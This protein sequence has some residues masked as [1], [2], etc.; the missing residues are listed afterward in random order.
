MENLIQIKINSSFFT[1]KKGTKVSELIS[2]LNLNGSPLGVKINGQLY[3]LDFTLKESV[4]INLVFP[5]S[6]DGLEI[7]RHSTAHLM[8]QA[9]LQL[10]PGTKTGIGPPIE[11]GYYY[12]FKRDKPFTPEDLEKIEQRM[13]ELAKK[14]IPIKKLILTKEEAIKIFQEKSQE[15]KVE[16]IKEKGEEEVTCYQQGD[17]I[18]FCLGPHLS[19]TSQIRYFKILSSSGAYWKGDEGGIRL[20][21]IYGTAFFRKEDLENYLRAMEEARKRDH[22]KLGPELDLFSINEEIGAGLILWHPKGAIIRKLI[23]DFWKEEHLKNGYDLVYTPHLARLDLWKQSGH[24][25]FYEAMYPPMKI[26]QVEYEIKPMNCPFHIMIY[27]SRQR[28][29]RDLPLRWA[30]L[31]TVYRFERSGVLHGLLRVRGFT[32]DD[33]HIFCS[34]EQLE[35]EIRNVIHLTLKILKTFGFE[36]YEVFLST[37]PEKFVGNLKDWEEATKA[38]ENSLKAMNLEYK[39]DLGEGVFYGPKIDIKIKDAL[40]RAWQCTTIQLDFNLPSRFNLTFTGKDGALHRPIM[41]HRAILGSLERFFGILIEHYKGNFPIWL[42]PVQA[43][44]LPITDKV[45]NYALKIKEILKENGIRCETDLRNEKISYKI[46][47]AEKNKI[48]YMIIIGNKEKKEN[49][50]SLRIHTI[51]DRGKME[52]EKFIEMVLKLDKDKSLKYII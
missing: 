17:F 46:R 18:D 27:K 42:S 5:D 50:I 41:I 20:Q 10:F 33:A 7:L 9:V 29:Y 39:I 15:L 35:A 6:E 31:G 43:I 52:L 37:R 45:N 28:S 51:G 49:N 8:A 26:D 23:E 22:R 14:N 47:E 44:V 21:R 40:G 4:E 12:D 32:Q 36:K 11:S 25:Q 16:L 2:K 38:L 48:P 13:R 19:S 1:V 34:S 24:T 30:E 3:D